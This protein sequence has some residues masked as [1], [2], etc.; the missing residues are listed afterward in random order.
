MRPA[1]ITSCA[2]LLV[3]APVFAAPQDD[4]WFTSP[5]AMQGDASARNVQ[6]VESCLKVEA[7]KRL[8]ACS[9]TFNYYMRNE[10]DFKV[11]VDGSR[12]CSIANGYKDCVQYGLRHT[13][14]VDD[15]IF[16]YDVLYLMRSHVSSYPMKCRATNSQ[17]LTQMKPSEGDKLCDR[18]KATYTYLACGKKF[19]DSIDARKLY[20]PRGT[21]FRATMSAKL[22]NH[23]RSDYSSPPE[24][25]RSVHAEPCGAVQA[26]ID[27]YHA[28]FIDAN[29]VEGLELYKRSK[30]LY[31]TIVA[32]F[33]CVDRQFQASIQTQQSCQER[34]VLINFFTCTISYH[35]DTKLI[36]EK[37]H[38]T[39]EV[40]CPSAQKFHRCVAS[41]MNDVRCL[42][43]NKDI[44]RHMRHLGD[45]LTRSVG[46]C[47]ER[48]GYY[49]ETPRER[50]TCTRTL[51]FKNYFQCGLVF[52]RN[53]E[54][55]ANILARS[56]EDR[57]CRVLNEYNACH[58][59][60]VNESGC[61]WK[62]SVL[63][64]VQYLMEMQ[65]KD[66]DLNC[67]ATSP[68]Y[69]SGVMAVKCI[70]NIAIK[71][72]FLCAMTFEHLVEDLQLKRQATAANVC[73]YL[74]ELNRCTE[75]VMKTTGC[76]RDEEISDHVT[77][78]LSTLTHSYSKAC[79][80]ISKGFRISLS[81]MK[82]PS[83]C[84]RQSVLKKLFKC[85]LTLSNGL[86]D[87][88][89][90]SAGGKHLKCRLL[91]HYEACI[92]NATQ[93]TDCHRDLEMWAQIVSFSKIIRE[94][95]SKVCPSQT[96]GNIPVQKGLVKDDEDDDLLDSDTLWDN[97]RQHVDRQKGR[98]K[99][100]LRNTAQERYSFSGVRREVDDAEDFV[101]QRG[102]FASNRSSPNEMEL[103]DFLNPGAIKS[104]TKGPRLHG[105][106]VLIG[107]E[108]LDDSD[109][110]LSSDDL[111]TDQDYDEGFSKSSIRRGRNWM[112]HSRP[113]EGSGDFGVRS[114]RRR[115]IKILDDDDQD[116]EAD[117]VRFMRPQKRGSDDGYDSDGRKPGDDDD[118]N[119]DGISSDRE[120]RRGECN[121]K[122]L[123]VESQ[124]CDNSFADSVKM[125]WGPDIPGEKYPG[126]TKAVQARLC[127]SLMAYRSC[128]LE[129]AHRMHCSEVV[130]KVS[131]VVDEQMKKLGVTTCSAC[132]LCL[133]TW[134]LIVFTSA[135]ALFRLNRCRYAI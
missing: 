14:C 106:K 48:S 22:T 19:F 111:N 123:K 101:Y 74:E 1:V 102:G 127:V 129:T 18:S 33:N 120:T 42:E 121:V 86:N 20:K 49:Q 17:L 130:G 119:N 93:G 133:S 72:T 89:H 124:L 5:N 47:K 125:S 27:C 64:T 94:D 78:I 3:V 115:S 61:L 60:A 6:Q 70:K 56:G 32:E 30:E 46:S 67:E 13:N 11:K 84:D 36:S 75:M 7:L 79:R 99:G 73:K 104:T 96:Y 28:D 23:L 38:A 2:A 24:L 39:S 66:I 109:D 81:K 107:K 118:D 15:E 8:F 34:P 58:K 45:V 87:M 52:E 77:P 100:A 116:E 117:I 90:R 9:S 103:S 31:D 71:N 131:L 57:R 135:A 95:Y 110:A 12:E 59:K 29:C 51:L 68:V 126:P 50:M 62:S 41:A 25:G 85:G 26:W 44:K 37:G 65:T 10:D 69:D 4:V 83:A 108:Y 114:G 82:P 113:L 92:A 63:D 53:F 54:V 128:L 21:R 88:E 97:M 43:E 122:K 134:T 98:G 16:A 132:R 80:N 76:G 91:L 40:T 35:I 105:Q 112:R 55:H